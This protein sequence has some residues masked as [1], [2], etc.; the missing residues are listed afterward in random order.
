MSKIGEIKKFFIIAIT[1]CFLYGYTSAENPDPASPLPTMQSEELS[2]ENFERC[3]QSGDFQKAFLLLEQAEKSHLGGLKEWKLKFIYSLINSGNNIEEAQKL[4][5]SLSV[6][7]PNDY[8][9]Q[10]AKAY[11]AMLHK[12]YAEAD[13]V[14]KKI[15]EQDPFNI[16]ALFAK[17]ELMEAQAEY[18]A[19]YK[20]YEQILSIYP[21][22]KIGRNLK[23]RALNELG[24][25]T[26]AEE[27]LIAS[28]ETIDPAVKEG[29]L[30]D[31]PMYRIKWQEAD[32][33]LEQLQGDKTAKS[34]FLTQRG[35]YDKILALRQKNAM[36][37][38]ARIYEEEVIDKEDLPPWILLA[39]ADAY[40]YLEKPEKA[41]EL[42]D[43]V[44]AQNWDPVDVKFSKY[45]T[46]IELGR[47]VPARKVLEELYAELPV[48]IVLRGVLRDN[49][50]KEV[51][52]VDLCWLYLYEDR[53]AEGHKFISQQLSAAPFDTNLRTA[54]AQAYL[55]RGWPR[56]AQEEFEIVREIDPKDIS[57]QVGYC[58]AL[59]QNDRGEE[60]RKL[61][62]ELLQQYPKNTFVQRLNRYF[63]VQD[64]PAVIGEVL[65]TDEHPGVREFIYTSR[66]EQ[67]IRAFRKIFASFFW[68]FDKED[69]DTKDKV[70]RGEVG[71]DWR[72]NRDWWFISALSLDTEGRNFGYSNDLM[73]N[74]NDYLSF[75]ASYDSYSLSLP[76]KARAFGIE[77]KE[78]NFLSRYRKSESFLAE[79]L[80][81]RL[82][83]SDNNKEFL[84]RLR[85]DNLLAA[86]VSWKARLIIE[87]N[88]VTN[89]VSEVPYYNPRKLYSVHL[90][91]VIEHTWFRRYERSL[92]DRLFLGTGA[93][94]QK[95]YS[96]AALWDI[97]YEQE[98]TF[99]D[100]LSFL[101]GTNFSRRNYD[102]SNCRAWSFDARF[103][104]SF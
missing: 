14:I 55:W 44:L 85:L 89:S 73:F 101:I 12:A 58:Y 13:S 54:L 91:P 88:V 2:R 15:L 38:V 20:H 40:L 102:G 3:L 32:I 65:S 18:L 75:S 76:L 45:Y 50:K 82:R 52:L 84:Y 35:L 53:L 26:L 93:L 23:Y 39:T 11:L 66:V 63:Q 61:A 99:S 104:Q 30:G 7:Y 19:A 62:K 71:L 57:G 21:E 67:P 72:L 48:Q 100:T 6:Q 29:I 49:I 81:T 5:E 79:L 96:V 103:K 25:T 59:N 56:L 97:R 31:K 1:C 10:L 83:F 86:M 95:S 94:W 80:I 68:R 34:S 78:W 51:A 24:A 74:P 77:G 36:E 92:V 90:T 64:M 46:L 70:K 69:S 8:R 16:E 22:T 41:L 60:A 87:G 27:K 17:G 28:K 37:E 42:Y 33:A 98:H 47:F 9:V 43:M 4:Q